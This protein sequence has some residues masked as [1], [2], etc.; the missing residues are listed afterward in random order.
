MIDRRAGADPQIFAVAHVF[1]GRLG[2]RTLEFFLLAHCSFRYRFAPIL[3][4]L[5]G[6]IVGGARGR[7]RGAA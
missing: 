1:I 4:Q 2:G 3:T 5:P 7:T 6:G